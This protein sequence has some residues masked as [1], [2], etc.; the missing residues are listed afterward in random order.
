MQAASNPYATGNIATNK[1]NQ[2]TK[3]S[4]SAGKVYLKSKLAIFVK[5]KNGQ[6]WSLGY[7]LSCLHKPYKM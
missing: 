3:R 4:V 7:M 2:N 6:Y 5:I 1:V